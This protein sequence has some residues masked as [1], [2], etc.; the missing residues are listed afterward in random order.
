M[1]EFVACLEDGDR[2]SH[3]IDANWADLWRRLGRAGDPPTQPLLEAWR[4]RRSSD[5]GACRR[6]PERR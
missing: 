6:T 5:G 4:R 3:V 2:L 1:A